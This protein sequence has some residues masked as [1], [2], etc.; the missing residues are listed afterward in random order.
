MASTGRTIGYPPRGMDRECAARY[1]GATPQEFDEL[2]RSGQMPR[3]KRIDDALI[4][5]RL[6]LDAAFP[7]LPED[8]DQRSKGIRQ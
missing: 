4:W 5:D 1:V 6:S 2:V 7:D 8:D 3:P